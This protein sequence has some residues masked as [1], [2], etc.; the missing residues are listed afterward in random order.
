MLTAGVLFVPGILSSCLM[1]LAH[2]NEPFSYS[3]YINLKLKRF[4]L[5]RYCCK[6]VIQINEEGLKRRQ[7]DL[8]AV[9][10]ATAGASQAGIS[11]LE[12]KAILLN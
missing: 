5:Y 1:S 4:H 11:G 6:C 2:R 3:K 7:C 8:T 12:V 9:T 10:E